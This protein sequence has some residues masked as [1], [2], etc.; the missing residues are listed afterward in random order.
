M[1]GG[2][3]TLPTTCRDA[4]STPVSLGASGGLGWSG[5]EDWQLH[6]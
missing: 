4:S 6:G 5:G 1:T 2:G 3:P